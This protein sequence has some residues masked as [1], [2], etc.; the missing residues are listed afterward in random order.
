MPPKAKPKPNTIIGFYT[1]QGTEVTDAA[2]FDYARIELIGGYA[3]S[4]K[5]GKDS[6]NSQSKA[7]DG[8][9]MT[10]DADESDPNTQRTVKE[11]QNTG[12]IMLVSAQDLNTVLNYKWY[13]CS[14][15][16]PGTY[17]SVYD[18]SERWGAPL[19]MH[20]FLYPIIPAGHVVDHINRDRLDNR[21]SNLR[22]ITAKQNSFNRKKP[23]N[24]KSAYKGVRKSGKS[25]GTFKA[26][27]SKDGK[28]YEIKGCATEKDAAIAY[29]M[30]AEELFGKYAGK[31]FPDKV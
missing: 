24:S 10:S 9:S 7:I 19:P 4:I 30:M 25:C 1:N 18:T 15:G 22:I 5:D 16:Y 20:R 26:V 14:S 13:L 8:G 17:G 6:K 31:N 2:D 28:T 3:R 11:I 23:V 27:I 12:Y 29:D 21:R